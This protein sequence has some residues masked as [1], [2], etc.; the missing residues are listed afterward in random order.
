MRGAKAEAIVQELVCAGIKLYGSPMIV[1]NSLNH[2]L[3]PKIRG[4]KCY[5]I[6][7]FLSYRSNKAFAA[8][9]L[10]ERPEILNQLRTFIIPVKEDTDAQCAATLFA[11]GLLPDENRELL[12][13]Q[14]KEAA[15]EHADSSVFEDDA[16][17][18]IL[19][20]EEKE[21]LLSEIRSEV[22]D[23][24]EEHVDRLRDSWSNDYDPD[25]HFSSFRDSM[26]CLVSLTGDEV[27]IA[28]V[29]ASVEKHVSYAVENMNEK[30]EPA[31]SVSAPSG[32]S[33]S[34][35]TV[36]SNLFRDIAD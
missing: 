9:V 20:E 32:P 16:L 24:V 26:K 21:E 1:P 22:L 17:S 18:D 31:P 12:V 15:L 23:K 2:L 10:Q 27:Y 14:L 19:T 11:F 3:L 28:K 36:L 29:M 34:K 5:E 25:E 6:P 30:Y 33:S 8:L 13:K 4:L 7:I 35:S